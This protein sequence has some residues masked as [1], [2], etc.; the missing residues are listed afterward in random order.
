MQSFV[1]QYFVTICS[2]NFH[3]F[4]YKLCKI[5]IRYLDFM[6]GWNI[7]NVTV[8]RLFAV[9]NIKAISK[10]DIVVTVVADIMLTTGKPPPPNRLHNI[11]YTNGRNMRKRCHKCNHKREW[12]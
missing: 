7:I 12:P 2:A 3:S 6:S 9:A 1:Y 4:V 5:V 10:F 8:C 11:C